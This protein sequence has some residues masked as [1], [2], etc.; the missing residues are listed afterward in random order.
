M[1]NEEDLFTTSPDNRHPDNG[2][3]HNE[4]PFWFPS[5]PFR[6]FTSTLPPF[7]HKIFL[8]IPLY[9]L[10]WGE[11][12]SNSPFSILTSPPTTDKPPQEEFTTLTSLRETVEEVKE[13]RDPFHEQILVALSV[14]ELG[15][16]EE[17]EE[18]R[19]EKEQ[20]RRG[21]DEEEEI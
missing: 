17:R 6:L 13:R 19:P 21:E 14:S 10:N 12:P 18:T 5:P 20:N 16:T 9:S 1:K 2:N 11:F 8:L 4:V 3:T 7:L 15:S